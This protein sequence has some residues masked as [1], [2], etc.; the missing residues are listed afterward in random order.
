MIPA[1]IRNGYGDTAIV[2]LHGI[3]GGKEMWRAQLDALAAAGYLAVAWDMPGYGATP[4]IEPYDMAG[5]AAALARLLDTLPAGRTVLLGHSMGG[6]VAQEACAAFAHR[7]AGLI[8]SGTSPAFG[9]PDGAWQQEFL[10]SRLAP[11]DA[12]RTMAELAPTLVAGM[13]GIAPE[14]AGAKLAVEVMS[15]VPGDTYRAALRAMLAFDRRA[16]LGA[17][18]VPALLIAGSRDANAPPAVM[19]KMAE[20]IARAEY[21]ELADCGHLACLEQPGAFNDAA[22]AFLARHFGAA[23]APA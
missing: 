17:I 12:G 14:P 5:L 8:L 1:T 6:M 10:R 2:L 23:P 22:L 7:I 4:P 9:K 11:L 18:R 19:R 20:R 3:G 13:V 16:A 21:V 15:R